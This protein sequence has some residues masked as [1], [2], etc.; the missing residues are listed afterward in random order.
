MA[1]QKIRTERRIVPKSVNVLR[2][3][4]TDNGYDL[5]EY[6]VKN[7]LKVSGYA[8]PVNKIKPQD[9]LRVL[10]SKAKKL[11]TF[12]SVITYAT[13]QYEGYLITVTFFKEQTS[14][15]IK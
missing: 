14:I 2:K 3:L 12:N 13:F 1:L 6:S 11:V 9:V 5:N 7:S 15:F 10:E 8:V 4:F